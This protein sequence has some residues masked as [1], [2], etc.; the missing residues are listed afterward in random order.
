MSFTS[1]QDWDEAMTSNELEIQSKA[2]QRVHKRAE[3]L[4]LPINSDISAASGEPG[5]PAG[6]LRLVP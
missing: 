2:V 4:G 6:L 3:R 5:A 1:G